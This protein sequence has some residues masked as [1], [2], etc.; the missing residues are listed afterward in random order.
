M[1]ENLQVR[2]EV[3]P[4]AADEVGLWL[5]SG[6]DAYRSGAVPAD[7]EPHAEVE[8]A[9]SQ[10]HLL[11]QARL[12]HSTSWRVDGPAVYLTY[13]VAIET[14]DLVKATYPNAHPIALPLAHHVGQPPT[15]SPVEA[16][17][18]RYIDVLLHG[19]RHLVY[20]R[21]NDATNG[22]AIPPNW[23]QHLDGLTPA[24]ARMYDK[25]HGQ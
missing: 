15:H 3:W 9:L 16:P 13:L 11:D 5:V 8:Y 7:N 25:H 2:V 10:H 18:P 12:I 4:I 24:L 23:Q 21:D 1:T 19:L 6:D 22:A 20:L 17:A 14:N